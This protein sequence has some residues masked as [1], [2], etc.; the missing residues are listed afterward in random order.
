MDVS[1]C[2]TILWTIRETRSRRTMRRARRFVRLDA[3]ESSRGHPRGT[4]LVHCS[5]PRSDENTASRNDVPAR[6]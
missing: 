1:A 3:Q 6:A 2:W 4:A 5:R